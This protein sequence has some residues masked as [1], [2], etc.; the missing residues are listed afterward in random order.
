MRLISYFIL[1]LSILISACNHSTPSFPPELI[2]FTPSPHN[3][4]F[5]GTAS[6]ADWDEK[7]RERGYILKEDSIYH[8]WYTGYKNSPNAQMK[9]GYATSPDGLTWTRYAGNPIFDSVW[10]EDMMVVKVGDTYRFAEG[11]ALEIVNRVRNFR[12]AGDLQVTDRIHLYLEHT[13][14]ILPAL[15]LFADYI[16]NEVLADDIKLKP[17][18]NIEKMELVEGVEVGILVEKV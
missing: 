13:H 8:M 18:P 14:T 5:K 3:P 17:M 15:N 9:L 2:H 4:I 1:T 7:I 16:K 12:K 6:P 11:I 10:T